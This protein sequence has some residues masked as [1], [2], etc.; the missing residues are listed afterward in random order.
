MQAMTPTPPVAMSDDPRTHET[1]TVPGLPGRFL[2]LYQPEF[3]LRDERLVGCEALLRWWHDDFGMLHPVAALA[4]TRWSGA[5]AEAQ[6]WV[7]GAACRQAVRWHDEGI[8]LPVA[9]NV[10]AEQ[11]ASPGFADEVRAALEDS[12]AEPS[13]LAIDVPGGALSPR[14]LAAAASVEAVAAL[15]VAVI[16]DL[17]A[18]AIPVTPLPELPLRAVKAPASIAGGHRVDRVHPSVPS[19]LRQADDLGLR[20]VAKALETRRE[21][22][23]ARD[24]GFDAGFGH[25]LSPPVT[26]Q[27]LG[28][29]HRHHPELADAS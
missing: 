19:L 25:H 28:A 20:T 3:E 9:V 17:P 23:L 24:A 18:G 14:A 1:L 21:V 13:A 4:G 15:E 26:P 29:L 12:G 5:L 22:L 10:R 7:L 27:A 6:D 11:V 2:V 16:A 8:D